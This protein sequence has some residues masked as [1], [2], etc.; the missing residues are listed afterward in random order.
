MKVCINNLEGKLGNL[1]I[2][3]TIFTKRLAKN[4]ENLGV[5]VVGRKKKHDILLVVGD[6]SNTPAKID[7]SRKKGAKIVQRLD[8]IYHTLDD[9]SMKLNEPIQKN[10]NKTDAVIYQ[11]EFSK[12][13]VENYFGENSSLNFIINNG[14]DSNKFNNKEWKRDKKIFLA[15]AKWRPTKRLN[16]IL[17]GFDY[18]RIKDSELWVLGKH[19]SFLERDNIKYFEEIS[20]KD[21]FKFYRLSDFFIHLGVNDPCPNAVVE[22]L[23]SGLPVI[24]SSSGGTKELVKNSGEVIKE[25]ES[26]K[27][28]YLSDIEKIEKEK[29]AGAIHKVIEN[30]EKYEFPREDLY[31]ENCAKKYL[32]AFEETL[33]KK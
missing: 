21:L 26:L 33:D 2:G 4:L 24:C 27:P 23:V 30:K 20:S 31:I 17:E 32:R 6:D 7:N 22:A 1:N 13:L 29:V 15:S 16:S 5:K 3:P 8:G 9:D 11:S 14:V 10:F 25:N 12:R 28:F 18:A 19:D